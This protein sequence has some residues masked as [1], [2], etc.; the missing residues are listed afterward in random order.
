MTP[1]IPRVNL[2][3]CLGDGEMKVTLA[4]HGGQAAA[5]NLR[6]PPQVVEAKALPHPAAEE[7]VRLVAAAKAAP[8]AKDERPARGG[9]V[10]SYTITVDDGAGPTVLKQSDIAMSPEFDALR[11]WLESH[12]AGK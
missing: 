10:M 4:K 5:I 1:Y 8:A 9:D 12:T 6:L 3:G 11:S 7:L 2:N